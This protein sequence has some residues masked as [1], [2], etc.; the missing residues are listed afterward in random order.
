MNFSI[1]LILMIYI[2][3]NLFCARV[4]KAQNTDL[5]ALKNFIYTD[6]LK[7]EAAKKI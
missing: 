5:L 3:V 1:K 6:Y 2:F 7:Q 4:N